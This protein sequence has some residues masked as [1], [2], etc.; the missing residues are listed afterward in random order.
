M[1]PRVLPRGFLCV[2]LPHENGKEVAVAI[3]Q[4]AGLRT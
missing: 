1:L 3:G 2:K 4:V